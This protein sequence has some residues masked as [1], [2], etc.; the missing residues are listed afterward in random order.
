MENLQG[1]RLSGIH[2]DGVGRWGSMM[3]PSPTGVLYPERQHVKIG[4]SRRY[5][6]YDDMKVTINLK[7]PQGQM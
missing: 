6:H 4:L 2:G 7:I 1:H 5:H 3:I